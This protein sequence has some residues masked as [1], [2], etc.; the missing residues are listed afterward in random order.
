MDESSEH[1][2]KCTKERTVLLFC[3]S[4][5]EFLFFQWLI[6]RRSVKAIHRDQFCLHLLI[7]GPIFGWYGLRIRPRSDAGPT[8]HSGSRG[9]AIV[10]PRKVLSL[11][12]FPQPNVPVTIRLRVG[13]ARTQKIKFN[14]IFQNLVI[15][16]YFVIFGS[17]NSLL[18]FLSRAK[19]RD[20]IKM[21]NFFLT[22]W[23]LITANFS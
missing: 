10:R 8:A 13:T 2:K 9:I 16:F 22:I 1:E 15:F 7:S 4:L 12:R 17:L 18:N 23:Y 11:K 5:V 20:P 14:F 21:T 3:V 6:Y 19:R